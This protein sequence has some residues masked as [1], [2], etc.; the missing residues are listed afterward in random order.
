[1]TTSAAP[2]RSTAVT[3]YVVQSAFGFLL[4]ALGPCL[5][6]LARDLR[7]PAAELSWVSA[8]FG[9]GLLVVGVLGERLM[10]MGPWRLHRL[11]AVLLG[12][13]G[14]L[15]ALSVGV[16]PAR[17][18]AIL[19]G[20]GGA[21][22][23]LTSPVL[24]AGPGGTARMSWA[25]GLNSLVGIASGPMMGAV[26][27]ATGHGRLALL[28]ALPA[29]LWAILRRPEPA[30]GAGAGRDQPAPERRKLPPG[31]RWRAAWWWTAIVLAVSPE[32]AFVIWGAARLQ[33]SGLSPSGA[34]A[35]A[36]AFPVGMALGRMVIVPRFHGQL[37]LVPLGVALGV[38]GSLAC[39]APLPPAAIVVACAVAGLGIAAL[40]PIS[41]GRLVKVPGLDPD[42]GSSVGATASGV[43]VLLAPMALGLLAQ[44]IPL[45]WGFLAAPP[46]LLGVLALHR[47]ARRMG[48]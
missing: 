46:L 31:A 7:R 33:A 14:T 43:A 3:A 4:A 2:S 11:S 1:V 21:G 30:A 40:Y 22:V 35:A 15:L 19:L 23:A 24:L 42:R 25:F 13:G 10:R 26:D 41:I 27:A 12:L 44:A 34:S 32:F 39:A 36:A 18:G 47:L 8:G 6:V 16:E 48:V 20:L 38:A 9:L 17:T 28:L 29:L 5:V 37:P 45:R